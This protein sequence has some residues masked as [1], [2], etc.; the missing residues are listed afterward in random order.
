MDGAVGGKKISSANVIATKIGDTVCV[1]T[2]IERAPALFRAGRI[3][4]QEMRD[5][6]LVQRIEGAGQVAGR[7]PFE[8]VVKECHV[9]GTDPILPGIIGLAAI[10]GERSR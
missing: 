7:S 3:V 1:A 10:G 9:A 5:R 2:E 4:K 8:T 6:I